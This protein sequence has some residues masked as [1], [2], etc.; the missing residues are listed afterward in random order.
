MLV[1]VSA[2]RSLTDSTVRTS[3]MWLFFP[4][5]VFDGGY[6]SNQLVEGDGQPT[7]R[8]ETELVDEKRVTAG[9]VVLRR[10]T[11]FKSK[12]VPSGLRRP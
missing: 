7:D 10:R 9:H 8:R 4:C 6:L 12:S 1:S 2:V 5:S 11:V 3:P